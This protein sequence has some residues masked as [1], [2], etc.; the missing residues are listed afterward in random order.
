MNISSIYCSC[1]TS[2]RK[3]LKLQLDLVGS[4]SGGD[5]NADSD[6][7]DKRIKTTLTGKILRRNGQQE[8]MEKRTMTHTQYTDKIV[9]DRTKL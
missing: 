6:T 5:S 9:K 7:E 1:S 2:G 3:L 4:G 8:G